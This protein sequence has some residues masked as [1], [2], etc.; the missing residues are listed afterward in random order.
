MPKQKNLKILCTNI[1]FST[2]KMRKM[3]K[4]CTNSSKLKNT[5]KS[6]SSKFTAL[7]KICLKA[8]LDICEKG[9]ARER[10][11]ISREC[12]EYNSLRALTFPLLYLARF[13]SFHSALASGQLL[14]LVQYAARTA[15]CA[16]ES[17]SQDHTLFNLYKCE[18]DFTL[19]ATSSLEC[20]F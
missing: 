10:I 13:S 15:I 8:S 16:S 5:T 3:Q 12:R 7:Q 4:K 9:S 18:V 1:H 19:R 14:R 17:V 11:W 20:D 6:K 2:C